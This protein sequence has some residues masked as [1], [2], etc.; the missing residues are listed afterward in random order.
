MIPMKVRGF[1]NQGSGLGFITLNPKKL[2][3]TSI[4]VALSGLRTLDLARV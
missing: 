4:T 2:H 3:C 1:I